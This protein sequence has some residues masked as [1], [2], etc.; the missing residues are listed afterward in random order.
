MSEQK[1]SID[2]VVPISTPSAITVNGYVTTTEVASPSS[3]GRYI[4]GAIDLAG[5]TTPN[6]YMTITNPTGSG[7]TVI[8]A[9]ATIAKYTVNVVGVVPSLTLT[10][11]SAVSGGTVQAASAICKTISS[12]PN[13][14]AVIRTGNPTATAGAI[15][16]SFPPVISDK[17]GG[18]SGIVDV[19][20]APPGGGMFLAEGESLLLSAAAGDVDQRIDITLSWA[21]A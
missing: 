14:V 15:A 7:R 17:V 19:V 3:I 21:E 13:A 9:R 12:Y 4:F 18:E 6:N 16:A 5:T 11:A 20:N 8:V 2:G 1:V 10:R